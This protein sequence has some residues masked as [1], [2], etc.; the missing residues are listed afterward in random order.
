[1]AE[2]CTALVIYRG[3]R[4]DWERSKCR[5]DF[6]QGTNAMIFPVAQETGGSFWD[7]DIFVVIEEVNGSRGLITVQRL[8][9]PIGVLIKARVV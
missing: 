2:D 4:Y 8:K 5:E 6:W 3:P 1:M 9:M 7:R